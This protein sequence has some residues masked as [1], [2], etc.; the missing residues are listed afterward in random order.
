MEQKRKVRDAREERA[1]ECERERERRGE[2]GVSLDRELAAT[3]NGVE[4]K[5][6]VWHYHR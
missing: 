2:E 6:L 5:R 1:R 3:E 4:G